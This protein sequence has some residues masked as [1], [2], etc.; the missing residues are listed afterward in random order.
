[1]YK[2]RIPMGWLHKGWRSCQDVTVKNGP[3][4]APRY[5]RCRTCWRLVTHGMVHNGGC[6]CGYREMGETISLTWAEMI[7]L[8]L[9][10]F[11]LRDWEENDIRPFFPK[12][13]VR[14]RHVLFRV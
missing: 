3:Q 8:K 9:G 5:L 7:L 4:G 1:M 12:M 6:I 14:L 11:M 13:G 2:V 10:W